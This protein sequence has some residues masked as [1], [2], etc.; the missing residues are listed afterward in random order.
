MC[1]FRPGG[2]AAG[3]GFK[4]CP[5][6]LLN[7]E[8]LIRVDTEKVANYARLVEKDG[9][10]H[11]RWLNP[12]YKMNWRYFDHYREA[13]AF[14]CM[15]ESFRDAKT[16]QPVALERNVSKQFILTAHVTEGVPAGRRPPGGGRHGGR[17]GAARRAL[18][19]LHAPVSGR[20]SRG[21]G[22]ARD[23]CAAAQVDSL[24]RP[25]PTLTYPI[26]Y[27]AA[28]VQG[29]GGWDRLPV[30][31]QVAKMERPFGGSMDF[32]ETDVSTGDR[33]E[34]VKDNA[35]QYARAPEWQAVFDDWG[36]HFR[37]EIFDEKAREIEAGALG[38]GSLEGYLAPGANTPYAC[39]LHDLKPGG[40]SVW[41]TAYD[42]AG[43]RRIS[44]RDRVSCRE[45]TYSR[46]LHEGVIDHWRDAEV[47]DPAFYATALKPFETRLEEAVKAVSAGMPDAEV[48]RLEKA[49]LLDDLVDFRFRVEALRGAYLLERL[50]N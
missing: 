42:H 50:T 19:R 15:T 45:E 13:D 8:D 18:Q 46:G 31:P 25:Q 16:L 27:S 2:G 48:F 41:N 37:V 38:A 21:G 24:V 33:G 9:T 20:L 6:L 39:F 30:K 4:L 23:V 44:E 43:H 40:F 17:A 49:A 35:R 14:P 36:L 28:A 1:A 22:R 7:D 32:L 11:E 10:R 26:R 34:V 29:I 47:G 3:D 12:P 5:E